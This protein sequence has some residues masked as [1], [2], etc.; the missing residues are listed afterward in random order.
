M[1]KLNILYT[2]ADSL[3]NKKD[4][5]EST[6]KQHNI[7]IALICETE[8]KNQTSYLPYTPF[9]LEGYDSVENKDGRGVSIFYKDDLEV[10]PLESYNQLFSPAIFLKITSSNN[11]LHLAVVYRSPNNSV[12][13]D[14]KINHQIN[15]AAK[16]LK[17]LVIYGDFNHPEIDW[18]NMY[19]NKHENHPASMFL[20][21]IEDCKLDQLIDSETHFNQIAN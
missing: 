4:E 9:F 16:H 8:P 19:C 20:H 17:N 2:N 14:L 5:L 13:D 18:K 1:S 11:L 10:T 15:Q 3:S 7:D 12:Q 6:I 21:S